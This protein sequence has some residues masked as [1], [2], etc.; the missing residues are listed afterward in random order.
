MEKKD[1]ILKEKFT[2]LMRSEIV[3]QIQMFDKIEITNLYRNVY[4][5][6]IVLT[7]RLY[8][9][10]D[11]DSLVKVLTLCERE[12]YDFFKKFVAEQ[13]EDSN[14]VIESEEEN[15]EVYPSLSELNMDYSKDLSIM[16]WFINVEYEN[17]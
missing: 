9:Y 12:L 4:G 7:V 2:F 10:G 11:V 1:E 17:V 15:V 13:K 3:E 8:T 5:Y 6:E 16:E 14:K